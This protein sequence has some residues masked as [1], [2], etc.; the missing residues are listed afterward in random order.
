[1]RKFFTLL[2][3]PDCIDSVYD[4]L[5]R[6]AEGFYE[7]L[8]VIPEKG[9]LRVV[10]ALRVQLDNPVYFELEKMKDQQDGENVQ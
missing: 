7:V 1:M 6:Q 8:H 4:V 5:E 9:K 2:I 10:V 3:N